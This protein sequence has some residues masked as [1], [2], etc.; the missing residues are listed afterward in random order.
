MRVFCASWP[1]GF[2]RRYSLTMK[3][4]TICSLRWCVSFY[5][6]SLDSMVWHLHLRN[7]E[8]KEPT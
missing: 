4:S 3:P 2:P 7:A 1:I 6:K 8:A 5:Q